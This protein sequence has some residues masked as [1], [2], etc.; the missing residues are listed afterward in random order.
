MR[1]TRATLWT[2]DLPVVGG[3]YVYAGATHDALTTLILRLET[4][5]GLTGW[6][7]SCPLGATYAPAFPEGVAAALRR[8]TR[9]LMG[10]KALPRPAAVRMEAEMMGQPQAKAAVD[11]ALWDILGKA[12]GQPVH[13]LLGG[14]LRDRIPSYFA[15]GLMDPDATAAKV[16]A[17]AA[18]GYTAVQLKI[19][20]GDVARDAACLHAAHKALP[21]GVTLTADANRAL[22]VGDAMHLSRLT[23]DLPIALEQPCA[24]RAELRDLAGKIA[25]PIYWDEATED[26]A[27]TMDALARGHAQ[28]LGMK[29][30]RVGG[31]SAMLAVRDMAAARRVPMSVD[32]HW[33]GD[34]IAAAC[35]HLGATVAPDLFRGTWLAQP[36]VAHHYGATGPT[37]SGGWIDVP[38]SPGLGVTPDPARLGQPTFEV[39]A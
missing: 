34:I 3:P 29:I 1:L 9:A 5:T 27:L 38:Q 11:I 15:V 33:G 13:A 6:G 12:T 37:I 7:E 8:L 30:T 22:T 25:H 14:A 35:V 36:Y 18:E 28:G 19:G 4:D 31:I 21:K 39:T 17:V 23:A 32:D 16:A 2:R 24:T 26:L 20:S 10:A